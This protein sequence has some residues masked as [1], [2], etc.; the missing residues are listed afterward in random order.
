MYDIS[1]SANWRNKADFG[2]SVWRNLKDPLAPIQVHVQKVRFNET[3][4]LGMGLF[5]FD[6]LTGCYHEVVD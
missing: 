2:L 5:R 6:P 3:G 1:G 4:E